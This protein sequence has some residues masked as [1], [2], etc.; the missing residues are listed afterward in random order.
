MQEGL[1]H[2][3]DYYAVKRA[4][5]L[6]KL[7]MQEATNMSEERGIWVVGK[8]RAGKSWFARNAFGNFYIK[9]QNKWW[10]GY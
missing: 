10:D 3:K 7:D 1:I 2:Y 6:I 5:D 9:S 4:H 8:P